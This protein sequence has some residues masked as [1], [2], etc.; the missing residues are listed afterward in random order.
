MYFGQGFQFQMQLGFCHKKAIISHLWGSDHPVGFSIGSQEDNKHCVY[1]TVQ[2]EYLYTI[3]V[4][5]FIGIL[6]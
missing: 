2:V 4:R 3:M 5:P 1:D 6:L